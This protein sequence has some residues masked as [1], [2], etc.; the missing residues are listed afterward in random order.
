MPNCSAQN[1]ITYTHL[2][3]FCAILV[4]A[5]FLI[6]TPAEVFD[7]FILI[8]LSPSNLI[9]DYIAIA[10]LGAT[11]LNSGL[12]GIASILL[13]H[14][15]RVQKNGAAIA[16]ILTVCGFAFFGKTIY[17]SFPITLGAYFYSLVK[18]VPF[19][20]VAVTSLFATALGPLISMLSFG[21]NL[22][23]WKGVLSGFI[24]GIL[25]GFIVTPLSNSF[26]NFHQGF[27][28]YNTGFTTGIIGMFAI[29]V[30]RM[31]NLQVNTVSIISSGNN[32]LLSVLLLLLFATFLF[33]GLYYNN[34]S[35][36]N[37]LKLMRYSGRLRTDF[38]ENCGYGISLIN[39]A[40]MGFISWLYILLVGAQINGPSIGALLT[41]MGFSAFGKHPLNTIPVFF[42][43]FA[44]SMINVHSLKDTISVIAVL[45]ASTLAPI[46]GRFGIIAGIIAGFVHVSMAFNIAYLHGGIN[47]Y[48]N[49]FSGGFV[50]AIL[51]PIFLFVSEKFNFKKGLRDN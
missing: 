7:G 46:A 13:L 34:W 31:F 44:A 38:V 16:G 28:L 19:K 45:F 22:D 40:I 32:Y 12:I 5:A 39:M 35:F 42:G 3:V 50:A 6:D 27:N 11:L 51:L 33:I 18:K 4:L 25:I 37:Y 1:P 23:I 10:G 2:Y 41:I 47:L 48:N 9:T 8:L 14:L 17:N 29:G 15:N 21:M 24:S 49:G 20:E 30:L 43:A 36:K 26:Y